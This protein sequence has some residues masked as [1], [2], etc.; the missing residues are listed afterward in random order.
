MST[1]DDLSVAVDGFDRFSKP[2]FCGAGLPSVLNLFCAGLAEAVMKRHLFAIVLA[3]AS[4]FLA[5][6]AAATP[7]VLTYKL[8]NV[9]F[10]DGGTASGSFTAAFDP[11]SI[12]NGFYQLLAVDILTTAGSVHPG[13]HYNDP[14]FWQSSTQAPVKPIGQPGPWFTAM[15]LGFVTPDLENSLMF[16]FDQA[17]PVTPTTTLQLITTDP[18]PGERHDNVWRTLGSGSLVPVTEIP[19]PASWM[20]F[21]AGIG[22]AYA[23]LKWRR[24]T[25]RI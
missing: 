17:I 15:V 12:Y 1:A 8:D 18:Y 4:G 20:I 7:M 16:N 24:A 19:E 6:P 22:L 10:L 5:M 13:A 23:G 25:A 3:I 11:S 14:A 21:L 9:T 2:F